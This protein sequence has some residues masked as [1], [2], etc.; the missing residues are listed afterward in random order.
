VRPKLQL[1]DQPLLDRILGEAFT[2]LME[3]GIRVQA[4]VAKELLSA[5]GVRIEGDVARIPEPVIRQALKTVPRTFA[6]HDREGNAAVEYGGDKVHFDPGSSCVHVL[7]PETLQHRESQAADLVRLVQV[8]EMLPA[9]SA[10]STAMVCADVPS[11]IGDLYRLFLVLW[12]SNKPVVTGAF[13]GTTTQRMIDLLAADAGSVDAL[14][15]KPR[16]IFDVCPSAPLHWTDFAGENLVQLARA[17]VPAEIISVPL[18]GATAPVTLAGAVVQHAAEVLTG[19]A[20]HQLAAPGAPVVWGGAPAI[21]D[22]RSGNTPMGAIETAMLEAACAQVGKSLGVPTH[23][24]LCGSD[25]KVVD[26]QSGME[27]GMAALVGVLAGINMV[28]GAGML[29]F[30]ACHSAEKL[31]IDAEAIGMAQRFGRGIDAR[32]ESLAVAMFAKTGLAGEFLKL[33]ETRS[34]FKEEQFLPSPVTDRASLRTWEQGG[35]LDT[36]ARARKQVT[37]LLADYRR[38]ALGD[39][40]EKAM[41][42]IMQREAAAVGLKT[43]PGI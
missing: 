22:M 29:D 16:A 38:P 27:T 40:R 19:I 32:G 15:A 43:L 10:Q 42:A 36:F 28:S 3:T 31:V 2:L 37:V 11:G 33:R 5:N 7:D 41:R 39:A 4:A 1:L 17:G 25:A 35:A 26:A 9:Y 30:L 6:L 23:G 20:I 8:A 13:S 12:Y 34:L 14:R 24:Y 21:F 18:A